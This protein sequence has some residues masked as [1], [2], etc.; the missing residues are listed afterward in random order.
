LPGRITTGTPA[1]GQHE[2][3]AV[4]H[5]GGDAVVVE[6]VAGQQHDV[7]AGRTGCGQHGGEAGGAIAVL[8]GVGFIIDVQ[9]GGVDEEDVHRGRLAG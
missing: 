1:A 6:G 4:E 9:V 8:C 3:G 7:G 2:A 5:R